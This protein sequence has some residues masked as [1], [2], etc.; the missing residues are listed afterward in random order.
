MD[1][2]ALFKKIAEVQDSIIC[3]YDCK[4][5]SDAYPDI[6][7]ALSGLLDIKCEIDGYYKFMPNG[8]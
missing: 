8:A 6:L 5:I 7:E 1:K 4:T 3:I 2:E